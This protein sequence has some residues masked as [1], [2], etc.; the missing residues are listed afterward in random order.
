MRGMGRER[1]VQ[2]RMSEDEYV[3]LER[4]ARKERRTVSDFVREAI[5]IDLM[6]EFDHTFMSEVRRQMRQAIEDRTFQAELPVK[7]DRR[8]RA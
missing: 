6:M 7:M 4:A 5:M 3:A 8:K 1:Q 2:F